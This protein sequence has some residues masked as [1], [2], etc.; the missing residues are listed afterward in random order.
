M[1]Y[2]TNQFKVVSTGFTQGYP[3]A[4]VILK[5][6]LSPTRKGVDIGDR[7]YGRTNRRKTDDKPVYMEDQTR[8]LRLKN[9]NWYDKYGNTYLI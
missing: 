9:G 7:R 5:D 3:S 2:K 1:Q 6:Y 8:H 4:M